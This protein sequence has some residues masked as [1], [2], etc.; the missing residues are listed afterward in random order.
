LTHIPGGKFNSAGSDS[1][2]LGGLIRQ[3]PYL[4]GRLRSIK[5]IVLT[6]STVDNE[7]PL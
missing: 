4:T 7:L 1:S 2:F 5:K 6:V 3:V